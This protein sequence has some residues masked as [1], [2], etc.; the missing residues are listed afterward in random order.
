[1]DQDPRQQR[2]KALTYTSPLEAAHHVSAKTLGIMLPPGYH[3]LETQYRLLLCFG[4]AAIRM[5][6]TGTAPQQLERDAGRHASRQH[7]AGKNDL[8][9]PSS[10]RDLLTG[11]PWTPA[12]LDDASSMVVEA[13]LHAI[14]VHLDGL[15]T[16]IDSHGYRIIPTVLRQIAQ[17]LKPLLGEQERFARHSGDK[18]LIF[19]TRSLEEVEALVE[20]IHQEISVVAKTV[21]TDGLPQSQIGVAS[22]PQETAVD[23]VGALLEALVISAEAAS[24]ATP[25]T[26]PLEA[27]VTDDRSVHSPSVPSYAETGTTQPPLEAPRDAEQRYTFEQLSEHKSFADRPSV[28]PAY[29]SAVTPSHPVTGATETLPVSD[30]KA[31]FTGRRLVLLEAN[32]DLTGQ[33]ATATVELMLGDQRVKGKAVGRNSEERRLPLVAEATARAA[34]EFM[35]RGYGVVI[36]HVDHAPAEVG[37]ALWTLVF[38]LTPTGEQGL[39]GIAP[40]D[41]NFTRAA[42]T[43]VLN[44]INRRVGMLLGEVN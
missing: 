15:D 26:T 2:P 16:L 5:Y 35:S 20:R 41:H 30:E 37:V 38:L 39:L 28:S 3:V 29:A 12:V 40:A 31:T 43:C 22:L 6:P 19:T 10:S 14:C 11:L 27:T 34:T 13:D 24:T 36:Q 33:V 32:L 23:E 17:A 21:G 42:A 18:L 4:D 44:A 7:T 8:V 25:Q 1:M 9:W